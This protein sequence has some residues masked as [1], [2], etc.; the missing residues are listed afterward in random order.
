MVCHAAYWQSCVGCQVFKVGMKMILF[1]SFY[2][3]DYIK[4]RMARV[5]SVTGVLWVGYVYVTSLRKAPKMAQNT[6]ALCDGSIWP[7]LNR[8]VNPAQNPV[9]LCTETAPRCLTVSGTRRAVTLLLLNLSKVH[10]ESLKITRWQ[11]NICL[12]KTA[13]CIRHNAHPKKPPA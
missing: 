4:V 7:C 12:T 10:S 6:T 1:Y 13:S 9:I 2:Q 11:K 3:I 5:S 8:R